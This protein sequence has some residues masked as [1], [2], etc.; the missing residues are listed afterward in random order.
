MPKSCCDY[1]CKNIFVK[2]SGL[3]FYG[4]PSEETQRIAWIAAINR[5][6]WSPTEYSLVC[7][8]LISFQTAILQFSVLSCS[9][10]HLGEKNED[11]CHPDYVPII[12]KHIKFPDKNRAK[13]QRQLEKYKVARSMKKD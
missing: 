2:G 10:M 13:Q 6:D 12:F 11:P 5:K 4:I 1:K 8:V 7:A 3:H 9:S